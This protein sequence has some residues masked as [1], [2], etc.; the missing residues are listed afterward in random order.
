MWLHGI[1]TQTILPINTSN[2]LCLVWINLVLIV[3]FK[4]VPEVAIRLIIDL[5]LYKQNY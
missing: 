1:I 5:A 3:R 4:Q 2:L